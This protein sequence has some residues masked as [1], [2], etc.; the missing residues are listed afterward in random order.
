MRTDDAEL[1]ERIEAERVRDPD[2]AIREFDCSWLPHGSGSAFDSDALARSIVESVPF[3]SPAETIYCGGDLGLVNDPSAFVAVRSIGDKID[4][5]DVL[6]IRPRRGQP[7]SLTDVLQRAAEFAAKYNAHSIR[8]DHHSLPQARDTIAREKMSLILDAASE[9]PEDRAFRF[10][11]L[12]EAF[13]AG[14][15]A[16]PRKLAPL[17]DQIARIIATPKPNGGYSFGAG[18]ADGNHCD[19]AMALVLACEGP[20]RSNRFGAF[21]ASKECAEGL[22][23]LGHAWGYV[24]SAKMIPLIDP[25][26]RWYVEHGGIIR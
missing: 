18:R 11:A 20:F 9:S 2:N 21:W 17:T 19:A 10:S 12:I 15:V 24:P 26:A 23:R 25:G 8:V 3:P 7:S 16:I 1:L 6:E 4:V 22:A 13:K 5:I 14:R